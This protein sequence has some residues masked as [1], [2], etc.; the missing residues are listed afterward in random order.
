MDRRALGGIAVGA[1]GAGIVAWWATTHGRWAAEVPPVGDVR[2]TA[3]AERIGDVERTSAAE[4]ARLR[5]ALEEQSSRLARLEASLGDLRSALA[6]CS[7]ETERLRAVSN[8]HSERIARVEESAGPARER[9][10][11]QDAVPAAVAERK[12][13]EALDKLTSITDGHR[14]VAIQDALADLVRLGDAVVP[15]VVAAL[16]S[17]MEQRYSGSFSVQGDR[18][19]NYAGLRLVLFDV[20][21]QIGTPASKKGFVEALGRSQNLADLHALTMYWGTSDPV[22]VDGVAAIAPDLLRRVA[23]VGL[24]KAVGDE[25]NSATANLLWWLWSHPTP[26]ITGALDDIV[27]QGL[28]AARH[29]NAREVFESAFRLLVR[30]APEQAAASVRVLQEA[31][32]G[33]RLVVELSKNLYCPLTQQARYLTYLFTH[34]EYP[35]TIRRELYGNFAKGLWESPRTWGGSKDTEDPVADAAPYL[36]FLE[37]RLSRETDE[38]AAKV[39]RLQLTRLREA[40]ERA[41]R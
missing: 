35:P 19:G 38:L 3:P 18:V 17:G 21:R 13:K 37:Q 29:A 1:V 6:Q 31:D 30:L 4:L 32:P 16:D 33:K 28:P 20:L 12:R 2:S 5:T 8:N 40:A 7:S 14:L 10:A 41:Q 23:K 15:D 9:A 24:E 25:A 39:L 11:A 22:L 36:A 34:E 27:R 26:E